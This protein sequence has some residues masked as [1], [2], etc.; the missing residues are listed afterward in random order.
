[1]RSLQ[2]TLEY[3]DAA[4]LAEVISHTKDP[5]AI[6]RLQGIRFRML[7]YS[8]SQTEELL[9]IR[10]QTLRHWIRRWNEG[11]VAA[12]ATLP[13]SGRPPSVDAELRDVVVEHL[14][15]H[16][17]DGTPYTAVAIH[18]YLKKKDPA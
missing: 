3:G 2:P 15:G 10:R 12:L 17:P 1:M 13:G 14:S 11:G 9:G 4:W 5:G 6:R 7:G 8:V 18:G 16:L